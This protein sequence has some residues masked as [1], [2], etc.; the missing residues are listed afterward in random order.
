MDIAQPMLQ[1]LKE[2]GY[3]VLFHPPYS[4][5]LSTMDYH[6]FKHLSNFLPEKKVST[7]SKMQKMLSKSL[8][9]PEALIFT[10][11]V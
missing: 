7:T 3:N 8:W 5:E 9:N 2:L 6:F 10:L 1:K 4:P 11:Q